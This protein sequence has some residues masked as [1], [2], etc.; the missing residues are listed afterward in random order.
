MSCWYCGQHR[1]GSHMLTD[2]MMAEIKAILLEKQESLE[3]SLGIDIHLFLTDLGQ[4]IEGVLDR[5]NLS[6]LQLPLKTV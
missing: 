3:S 1:I 4:E 2:A 5:A 6:Q